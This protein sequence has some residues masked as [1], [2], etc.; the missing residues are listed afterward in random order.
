MLPRRA[1]GHARPLPRARGT[2][3]ADRARGEYED[4][5]GKNHEESMMGGI[6][7][8][9]GG[10]IRGAPP[11]A[12]G[13]AEFMQGMFTTIEKV[14]RNTVQAMQVLVRATDT[15]VITVMKAFLQLLQLTF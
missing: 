5:D 11:A 6:A 13:G 12:F 8:A 7:N 14:V 10:K 9:L 2:F 3:K 4:G 15:R 1:R